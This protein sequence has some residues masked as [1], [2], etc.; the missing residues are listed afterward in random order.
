MSETRPGQKELKHLVLAKAINKID[1]ISRELSGLI[2]K[3]KNEP[4]NVSENPQIFDSM[5]LLSFLDES[6]EIIGH[7]TDNCLKLI[8]E[9]NE[10]LF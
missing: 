7:K 2:G 9:I 10:L 5:S 4:C 1:F 8:S 3:I 6:V